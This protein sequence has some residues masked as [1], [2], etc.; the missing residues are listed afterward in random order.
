M[1]ILEPPGAGAVGAFE[2]LLERALDSAQVSQALDGVSGAVERERL[3]ALALR[4]R[5]VIATVAAVEY[6]RYLEARDA[7]GR[8][9]SMG[10]PAAGAVHGGRRLRV[11]LGLVALVA[12]VMLAFGFTMG[13]VLGRPY[14][15]GGLMTA[16]M[17]TGAA[18]AGALAGDLAWSLRAAAGAGRPS[19]GDWFVDGDLGVRRARET[20][21]LALLER[22][23]VPFLLERI[24]ESCGTEGDAHPAR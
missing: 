13:A 2:R 12:A 7:R 9:R 1:S 18:A 6:Q 5:A 10:C 24:E 8:R 20:W 11:G 14:I 22:G 16:G 4:E 15:G 19:D 3:R 23:M 21:E 17:I